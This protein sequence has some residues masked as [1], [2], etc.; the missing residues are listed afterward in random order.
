M[1]QT[2]KESLLSS[3]QNL[4]TDWADLGGVIDTR[5]YTKAGLFI[6]VDIGSD[7]N[8]RVRALGRLASG[9]SDTEY[10]LPILT[11][12]A[13]VVKIEPEYIEFNVDAD[14]NTILAVDTAG[15]IPYV[16]FQVQTSAHTDG[17]ITSAYVVKSDN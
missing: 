11:V 7:E 13:S 15:V 5:N 16:Q 1:I 8:V 12:S 2:R 9:A 6:A 10:V 17:V 4:S 3:A 14:T